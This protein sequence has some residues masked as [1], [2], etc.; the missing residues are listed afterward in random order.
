LTFHLAPPV[1]GRR[2]AV[3]GHA[4]K[5]AFGPWMLSAMKLLAKLKHLRGTA[6]DVFGRSAERRMERQLIEDYRKQMR[7]IAEAFGSLDA[8]VAVSLAN[9]P[10][11]IRGFGHV[12]AASAAAARIRAEQLMARLQLARGTRLERA[13]A[14]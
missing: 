3:T 5:T 4:A 9:V 8:E 6:F 12:K 14:E 13:A 11:E 2:D 1:L 10:E 7:T